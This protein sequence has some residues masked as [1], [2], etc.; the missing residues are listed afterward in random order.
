[1][2][3]NYGSSFDLRF[4]AA[5]TIIILE[6]NT[7]VAIYRATKRILQNFGRAREDMAPECNE[8]FDFNFYKYI[9]SFN[10]VHKP[11]IERALEAFAK[12]AKVYRFKNSREVKQF[13]S[14]IK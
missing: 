5:D 6:P 11:R 10:K 3:G 7:I 8:R 1:M 9:W 2:D 14:K 12:S 13:L 4:S